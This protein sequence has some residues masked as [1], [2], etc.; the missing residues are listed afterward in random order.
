MSNMGGFMQ[1]QGHF[2]LMVNLV[3]R[4]MNA[5][6]AIDEPR[7]CISDGTQNGQ[8]MF[9]EGTEEETISN[10]FA[11]GHN[12]GRGELITS[13]GRNLFGRAQIITKDK[14]T[15]V[16]CGGSDG[17]ADGGVCVSY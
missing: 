13:F 1:P 2:T 16:L 8:V 17:R 3:D 9:E 12:L 7:F 5:Q 15:G 11:K 4:K 10:L 6:E 14:R